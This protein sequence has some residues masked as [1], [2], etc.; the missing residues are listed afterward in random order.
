MSSIQ[1]N[2]SSLVAQNNLN[3]TNSQLQTSLERLSSG[4]RINSAKDDAAGLA[5]SN[6]MTSQI[7][8]LTVGV[9]NANDGISL[10]QTAEGA[11]QETTNILQRMRDLAMQSSSD[12]NSDEDRAFLQKEIEQLKSEMDRIAETTTFNGKKILDGSFSNGN[13][14]VGFNA[15]ET[16]GVQ[17]SAVDTKTLGTGEGGA[18]TGQF[19]LAQ[20]TTTA[21]TGTPGQLQA[22]TSG[23]LELNG[24]TVPAAQTSAD[25]VSSTDNAASG[26]ALAAAI[27]SVSE[28]TGVVAEANATAVTLDLGGASTATTIAA[29]DLE[30]NGVDLAGTA[31]TG[32]AG[33]AAH[34]NSFADQTG[35]TASIDGSN[36]LTLT[37]ADGRNIEFQSDG[38]VTGITSLAGAGNAFNTVT[39]GTVTLRA[40][41]EFTIA[42]GTP[43]NANLSE[44]TI[45]ATTVEELQTTAGT[46]GSLTLSVTATATAATNTFSLNGTSIT[47]TGGATADATGTATSV[48]NMVAAINAAAGETGVT[49][50][51]DQTGATSTVVLTGGIG[52]GVAITTTTS[53]QTNADT[54]NISGGTAAIFGTNAAT[55]TGTDAGVDAG[56][57]ATFTNLTNGDLTVN[58]FS[59]DFS[60]TTATVDNERSTV[61]GGA[62]AQFIAAAINNTDGLKDQV[63]ATATTVANLGEVSA[64]NADDA[65]SLVVNGLTIDIDNPI[66]SDDANGNIAGTLNA[67]FAES[68]NLYAADPVTNAGRSD[69]AG[70]LASINDKGELLITANDGRNIT[71]SVGGQNTDN[72]L[73]GFNVTQ[74]G[75]VTAKGTVSLE[76]KDGFSVG[77]IGGDKRTLAGIESGAGSISNLD[78]S[79]FE[80]AQAA[81]QSVDNALAKIDEL[82]ADLGATQ[83]R[84][85]STISNLSNVI[86]NVSAGRSRI[87]DTDFASETANLT[88]NQILTQAGTSILAQANQLPQQV[89]SLLG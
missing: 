34:I 25:T 61:D 84:F 11:M 19:T 55:G 73:S 63:K 47:Y 74:A 13:F 20:T 56:T 33:L 50:E 29:G 18:S 40:N 70:L 58:G 54:V 88:K 52:A 64:G 32:N 80:G 3:K 57:D 6:R 49:A 45:S 2:L 37:A 89:L 78:I 46:A 23:D 9:R 12:A 16:I 82:R 24:V 5:I 48:A 35:V 30:I 27:N 36:V 51:V 67:A 43:E 62:S 72:L 85:E 41:D 8:S 14:Q 53:A 4:F 59:V 60:G 77:E 15:G 71:V 68:A 76:A 39:T 69:T 86:E 28:K 17:L 66:V 75:S 81:L 7:N 22:L 79:T 42:G 38:D 87:K 31:V 65:F 21:Q 26:I 1:T 44:S 83:N 10:A